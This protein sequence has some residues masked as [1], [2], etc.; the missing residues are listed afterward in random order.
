MNSKSWWDYFDEDPYEKIGR[1]VQSVMGVPI[2]VKLARISWAYLDWLE[3]T[4]QRN[5]QNFFRENEE[6]HDPNECDFDE[7]MEGAVH[8]G[9]LERERDGCPR[10][11][12]CPPANP[13]ELV[14][15]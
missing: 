11:D 2:V 5:I 1:H 8:Q 9:Y 7:W 3:Q 4:E 14:D 13:A 15:I 6:I 10:P 12:W